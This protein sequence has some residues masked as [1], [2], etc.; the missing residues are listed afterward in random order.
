M[1]S[2]HSS[3]I[4]GTLKHGNNHLMSVYVCSLLHRPLLGERRPATD[5]S[6]MRKIIPVN[7]P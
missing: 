4:S 6:R 1:R 2:F 7:F 3:V 5:C